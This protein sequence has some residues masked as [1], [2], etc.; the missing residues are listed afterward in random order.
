MTATCDEATKQFILT[1]LSQPINTDYRDQFSKPMFKSE[2][3]CAS[4]I[5]IGTELEGRVS[6]VTHFGAFVDVGLEK[7]GLIHISKMKGRE[8]CLGNKVRVNVDKNDF[9]GIGLRLVEVLG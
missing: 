5:A 6:N 8:L 3:V 1:S 9:K 4:K 7:D 2:I